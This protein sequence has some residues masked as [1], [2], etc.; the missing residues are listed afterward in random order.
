MGSPS[1]VAVEWE[2]LVMTWETVMWEVLVGSP[3]GR[4]ATGDALIVKL[5]C[6]VE[7]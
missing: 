6:L 2:G 3:S 4:G 1:D 7:L 5:M